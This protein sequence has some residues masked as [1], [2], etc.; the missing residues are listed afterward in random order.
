MIFTKMDD[1][2]EHDKI[3]LEVLCHLEEN[4]LYIKPEQC[5]FCTTEVDFLRMI[6]EKDSIKMDQETVKAILNWPALSNV[7]GVRSFLRLANFY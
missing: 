6:V 4:N 3:M 7:K 1:P 5:A 2:K